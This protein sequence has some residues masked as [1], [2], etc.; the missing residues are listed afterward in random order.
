M[1]FS[2]K[3]VLISGGSRGIGLEIAKLFA[4]LE[5]NVTIV[6]RDESRLLTAVNDIKNACVT[7]KQ[8]ISSVQLDVSRDEDVSEK[9]ESLIINQGCPDILINS[10]GYAH[11]GRIE[12]LPLELFRKLMDINFFGIVNMTK[13]VLPEMM[14]RRSGHIV[15]I[16][17]V[18]GFLGIYG[19]TAY[20]GSKFAVRGFSDA[21]RN[22][23]KPH[24]IQVSIV[25]PPDTDTEQLTYESQYKPEITRMVAG[26]AGLLK[27]ETVAASVIKG[28][29]RKQ[30]IITPGFESTFFF[31]LQNFAG[32][33]TYPILDWMVL[34]AWKKVESK[35]NN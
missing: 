20:S 21:L 25:F 5:A 27:P 26:N 15:N 30:Y 17:S 23:L 19:Y 33:I 16:S 6:A 35:R 1:D 28:I 3:N 34:N 9:V 12:E 8:N 4:R 10:A 18:S 7:Q 14:K 22:E 2:G 13:S 24:N 32:K 31:W 11:P 29:E